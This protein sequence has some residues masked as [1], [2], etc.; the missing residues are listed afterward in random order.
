MYFQHINCMYS[1][2]DRIQTRLYTRFMMDQTSNEEE[3]TYS[4]RNI[5][6]NDSNDQSSLQL[7]LEL[8]KIKL[9]QKERDLEIE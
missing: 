9:Q 4:E 7:Q 3:Q 1:S 2:R 5:V 6:D 8:E